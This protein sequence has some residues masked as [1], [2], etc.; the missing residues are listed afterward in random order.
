MWT[1]IKVFEDEKEHVKKYV[2]E[3]NDI[4]VESVLY[5]YPTYEERTVLCIS[6]MC[7]C[8]VGCRFCGTGDYFVRSL[9]ADEIVG[10]A[11]YILETQIGGLNPEKIQ[12]LQ[13][14]VMSMGEPLLVKALEKAFHKLYI[15]YPNAQ[16]LISSSGP[17]IDY[18]WVIKMSKDIP[19]VGLQFSIHESTDLARDK[20][21]PFKNKLNLQGISDIG[22]LWYTKTGRKPFFNYCAHERNTSHSDVREIWRLF[23]PKIWN[24]TVSVICE[25]NE[26]EQ[27]TNEYQRNLAVE[28]GNKLVEIGYDVR[29]FDPAGQDTIGGGCGQLWYTQQWMQEHP[30]HVRPSCGNG[31]QKIHAPM[32]DK[33][34]ITL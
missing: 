31:L 21:I 19:T 18:D 25:R 30:E 4:A 7:G 10:Q 3:R 28:F 27:S 29:V 11:S 9:T 13:I 14:M 16:L 5:R 12:K 34:N 20:L 17:D 24:A 1:N 26:F 6:T 22:Y 2:F 33:S 23:N 8:P 15:A 32:L